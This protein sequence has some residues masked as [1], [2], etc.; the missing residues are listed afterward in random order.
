MM[1]VNQRN[2][3]WGFPLCAPEQ[4][5]P[6][7]FLCQASFRYD[8]NQGIT[9]HHSL[10]ELAK[11]HQENVNSLKYAYYGNPIGKGLIRFFF[12][13]KKSTFDQYFEDGIQEKENKLTLEFKQAIIYKE[14]SLLKWRPDLSHIIN[15]QPN[16]PFPYIYNIVLKMHEPCA[17]HFQPVID[18]IMNIYSR[19][20]AHSGWVTYQNMQENSF[21]I[22]V[23]LSAYS[24]L[25][26]VVGLNEMQQKETALCEIKNSFYS[27]VSDYQT[28]FLSYVS[29]C[30]N[31]GE[32][33]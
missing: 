9:F 23:P 24:D 12:P 25:D 5:T 16:S 14:H 31:A 10:V 20:F 4:N 32:S 17:D 27:K 1:D 19:Q 15:K 29:N 13:S 7:H 3:N 11:T 8:V 6:S 26:K 33:F 30:S 21:Q 28:Y 22:F 2:F 18:Q